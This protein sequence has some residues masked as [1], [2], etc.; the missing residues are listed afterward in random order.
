[1][2][3]KTAL[4]S[5]L[6]FGSRILGVVRD[7]LIALYFGASAQSDAFFIAFR[8][9]DLSRKLFSEGILSISFIPVFTEALEKEG[10][11]RAAAMVFSFFFFFSII[12]ILTVVSDRK[13][14]V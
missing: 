10:R 14:V 12:G 6:T 13:S 1:M 3:K 11:P 5:L 4:I 8:P 9:F 2:L 7:A